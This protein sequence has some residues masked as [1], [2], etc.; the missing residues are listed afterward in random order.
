M[1][2]ML[3]P[4]WS[5]I[6][7]CRK[8]VK[9]SAIYNTL[10]PLAVVKTRP[11]VFRTPPAVFRTHLRYFEEPQQV[12]HLDGGDAGGG[13]DHARDDLVDLVAHLGHRATRTLVL[14]LAVIDVTD[15][16]CGKTGEWAR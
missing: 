15:R 12:G 16:A 9:F 14:I 1:N 10:H 2:I 7:V 6:Q 8:S 3:R 11:V 13:A 5:Q 4:L